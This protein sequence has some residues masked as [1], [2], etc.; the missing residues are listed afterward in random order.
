MGDAQKPAGWDLRRL[1]RV[2]SSNPGNL[3]SVNLGP[4]WFASVMGTGII[5]NASATLPIIGPSLQ[6]F[7]L[8]VWVVAAI[9]LVVLIVA[10]IAQ[11]ISNPAISKGHW[12]DPV[13]AQFYGAPP[14]AMLTVGTG[15]MIVGH[16]LIGQT[17]AEWLAWILWI[18]GT[19]TGLLTAV[20]IPYRLFTK[21]Q[22][23][24]DGAFGGW[25][26]PVVPPMVSATAGAFLLP[27]ISSQEWRET[28][29]FACYAMFGMSFFASLIIITLIWSRL[30]HF[31]STGSVRV[32][33]LWIVLGPLGQSI[34]AAGLLG[35]AALTAVAAP[36][37][38]ALNVASVIYGV[39][40]WG[41]AIMWA[42]IAAMMTI[43]TMRRKLP[44]ALTWWS[45][46][47]PVGTVVT[48]TTQL[49]KHTELPA[50]EYLA[51][52]FFVFLLCAWATVGVRTL[53]GAYRTEL[54]IPP[55]SP[56]NAISRKDGDPVH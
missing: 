50:F 46:T 30:A 42:C 16:E 19:A 9:L 34:T 22:I 43:R 6:T 56:P 32:P 5:A 53:R 11:W 28:M 23:R 21:F 47:F 40:V 14:M 10:Q 25:L 24:P 44:F 36:L 20:V 4:N 7:A 8:V 29:M 35:T 49:A 1:P 45:F 38:T 52:V 2:L 3:D 13:M 12:N 15:A 18:A 51:I 33:T 37:S 26:M 31:G 54:L 39:P 27:T 55:K 41:F 48:G 17:A